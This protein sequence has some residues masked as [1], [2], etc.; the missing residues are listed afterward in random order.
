MIQIRNPSHVPLPELQGRDPRPEACPVRETSDLER[1]RAQILVGSREG[2]W[3]IFHGGHVDEV[4]AAR[5][6]IQEGFR[7]WKSRT[8]GLPSRRPAFVL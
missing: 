1:C 2:K 6:R 7:G 8:S 5:S 4:P 3:G